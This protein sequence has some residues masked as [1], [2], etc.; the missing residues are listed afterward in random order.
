VVVPESGHF[1][2]EDVPERAAAAVGELWR[3]N[4]PE[5]IRRVARLNRERYLP[6]VGK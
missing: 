5:A 6:N 4:D 2:Q 3:R 1:L